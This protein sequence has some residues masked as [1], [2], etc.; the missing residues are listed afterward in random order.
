MKKTDKSV[1]NRSVCFGCGMCAAIC[2]TNALSIRLDKNGFYTPRLTSPET[3]TGCGM[4]SRVCN[5]SKP[6]QAEFEYPIESL[7]AWSNDNKIRNL[8][9]SGGISFEIIQKLV[10]E[11]YDICAVRYNPNNQTAEHYITNNPKELLKS[12][13]SKYLQSNTAQAFNKIDLNKKNVII[14]TPC[15][16]DMWRRYLRL[17]GK[18]ENFLLIDFFCHGVPSY[19]VWQKYLQ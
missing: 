1:G 19:L 15:Q 10:E 6:E 14:G 7:A 18:D 4:C 9:S 11:G 3:C 13:G 2:P 5:Y 8:C 16:I 17:R 12:C